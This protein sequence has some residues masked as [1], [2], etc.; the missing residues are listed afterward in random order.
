MKSSIIGISTSVA[1][2]LNISKHGIWLDVKGKEYFLSFKE[3]PWFKQANVAAV[4][5]VKLLHGYHLYWPDL[6][7]D[8]ELGSIEY[9]EKYPHMYQQK[10]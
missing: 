10:V 7:V 2:V 8:L 3:F 1:E 5:N 9:P 6:D 4:L